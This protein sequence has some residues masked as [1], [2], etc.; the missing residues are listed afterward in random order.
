MSRLSGA[1]K[2]IKRLNEL[3]KADFVRSEI[4]AASFQIEFD[5][6]QNASSITNAPPEVVQLISRSVINNGLT[7]V[8]NQNS[9][10]MGAYI[11][12]GTGGH[13]KVADEWR[14]MAWQFYVNGKGRLRAHPYMYP[15]FVKGRDMFIKSLR[16]KIRQ[17]TK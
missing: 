12:F 13:V 6:K 8:I 7:A 15:A 14:D 1:E 16:A 2:L 9:L 3:G 5:A 17:L 4:A 11:E 10:P